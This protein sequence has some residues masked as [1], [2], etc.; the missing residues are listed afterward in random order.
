MTIQL[1]YGSIR[2]G[3]LGSSSSSSTIEMNIVYSLFWSYFYTFYSSWVVGLSQK[4][5]KNFRG[6]NKKALK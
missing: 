4:N 1:G 3:E 2:N 6:W 5:H